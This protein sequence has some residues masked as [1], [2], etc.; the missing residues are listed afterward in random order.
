MGTPAIVDVYRAAVGWLKVSSEQTAYLISILILHTC[1][2]MDIK[3]QVE[4]SMPRD[5]ARGIASVK[6]F[7]R[8]QNIKGVHGT[9]IELIECSNRLH[10]AIEV[11]NSSLELTPTLCWNHFSRSM[12]C[13]TGC[14]PQKYL[15]I[16][17]CH[18]MQTYAALLAQV[19]LGQ[20]AQLSHPCLLCF[21]YVKQSHT[22]VRTSQLLI[23]KY[24]VRRYRQAT[25]CSM[26]WW[27][28]MM[29]RL[30]SLPC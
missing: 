17:L 24:C 13:V 9:L 16:Q 15:I 4:S 10:T 12:H 26:W 19:R 1:P 6:R 7:V 5:I 8:Q 20:Q 21:V 3:M 23:I 22:P 28:M 27:T 29:W 2:E 30:G 18:A 11:L 14:W 25:S